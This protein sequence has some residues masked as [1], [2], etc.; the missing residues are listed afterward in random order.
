MKKKKKRKTLVVL[1]VGGNM[2]KIEY[3][4]VV[5]TR[6]QKPLWTKDTAVKKLDAGDYSIEGYE[7]KI[8]IERKSLPDLFGT[9]GKGHARF[10]LELERAKTL[11][12]FAI[13]IE[14][15]YTQIKN[16]KFDGAYH[17]K[18]KGYVVAKILFT[19]HMKYK[20]PVFFCD[21]RVESKSVIKSIFDAYLL[22]EAG[23]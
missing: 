19:I 4:V 12:Y 7:T 22:Q 17:S 1:I 5:D 15:N 21:N 20:L 16:K 18:M 11:D 23:D 13:V 8:C 6:E 2:M 10:K 14:G 3:R 9:L